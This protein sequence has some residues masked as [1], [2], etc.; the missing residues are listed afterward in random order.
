MVKS[1]G[2]DLDVNLCSCVV[3]DKVSLNNTICDISNCVT[4]C[5]AG[6]DDD[7]NTEITTHEGH[8][9]GGMVTTTERSLD[10][11]NC[12]A[13]EACYVPSKRGGNSGIDGLAV[14]SPSKKGATLPEKGDED[15]TTEVVSEVGVEDA[16]IH[17][18]GVTDAHIVRE[19]TGKAC[20]VSE[21][22]GSKVDSVEALTTLLIKVDTDVE[23]VLKSTCSTD[24]SEDRD[25]A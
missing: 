1:G 13:V 5:G 14:H 25:D 16:A 9:F 8:G 11:C 18:D 15:I 12:I 19:E 22:V 2:G 6:G 3:T 24:T 21:V 10:N 7:V 4:V 23:I 17:D 20:D